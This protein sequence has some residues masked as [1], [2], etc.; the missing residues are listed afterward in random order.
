MLDVVVVLGVGEA[1]AERRGP[2]P[3]RLVGLIVLLPW[4][5][6]SC[7]RLDGILILLWLPTFPSKAAETPDE[8]KAF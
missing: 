2:F 7:R 8:V 3:A 4:I 6:A 1:F 5:A